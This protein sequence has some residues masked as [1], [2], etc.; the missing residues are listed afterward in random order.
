[1]KILK[2]SNVV[3]D[4]DTDLIT[5]NNFFTHLIKETSITGKTNS[6]CQYFLPTKFISTLMPC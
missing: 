5:V 3:N 2:S 1:M 6:S 4:I